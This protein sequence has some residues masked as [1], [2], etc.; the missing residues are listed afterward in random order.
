MPRHGVFGVELP[1]TVEAA[2]AQVSGHPFVIGVSPINAAEDPAAVGTPVL[3]RSFA[4]FRQ[5]FGYSA[6]TENTA[7][8][9]LHRCSSPCTVSGP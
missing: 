1:T 3:I 6:D 4:E 5:K 9:N 7:C 8:A 2:P